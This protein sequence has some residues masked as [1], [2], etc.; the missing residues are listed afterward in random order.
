M[1]SITKKDLEE[2]FNFKTL[3]DASCM[4]TTI[5]NLKYKYSKNRLNLSPSYQRG[6]VWDY[7]RKIGLI[8]SIF[9]NII[10]PAIIIN[11]DSDETD[12]IWNIIDGKQRLS[13][14]FSFINN[15]FSIKYKNTEVYFKD[16][17]EDSQNEFENCQLQLVIYKHLDETKQRDIFE[18]INYG[19]PL[20][21]SEK[22][23]GSNSKG[24]H[25]IENLINIYSDHFIVYKF[26]N[27]RDMYYLRFGVIIALT[28]KKIRD[29][30]SGAVILKYFKSWDYS[31]EE[32]EEILNSCKQNLDKL[33]DLWTRINEYH[34]ERYNKYLNIGQKKLWNWNELL[35]NFYYINE[36][37]TDKEFANLLQFNKFLYHLKYIENYEKNFNSII[38]DTNIISDWNNAGRKNSN[39]PDMY[40]I[41]CDV[42]ETV[43]NIINKKIPKKIKDHVKSIYF[44]NQNQIDC[45][46]CINTHKN[47]ISDTNFHCGHIISKYNGGL[48]HYKNL[49]PICGGCNASMGKKDMDIYCS[50]SLEELFIQ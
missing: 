48:I 42:M 43:L 1:N 19:S 29:A 36:K 38:K 31:S 14:I 13:T 26:K 32:E 9:G 37:Q 20:K 8:K 44:K 6:E 45:I 2:E 30:S 50:T 3:K 23:K 11:T 28:Q 39:N 46:V 41:R 35:F 12:S 4:P 25:L 15:E 34:L 5:T 22:L 47:P 21:D 10:L 24:L 27:D 7:S 33:Y 17:H 49:K 18:R 16:L 40:N